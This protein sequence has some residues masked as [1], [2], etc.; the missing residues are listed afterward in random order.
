[1]LSKLLDTQEQ[2][3]T[4]LLSLLE[5]ENQSL[6]QDDMSQLQAVTKQKHELL[7]AIQQTDQTLAQHA[8]QL[9]TDSDLAKRV[10]VL[11]SLLSECQQH[12]EVNGALVNESQENV[13]QLRRVVDQLRFEGTSTYDKDG[14]KHSSQ[15]SGRGFKA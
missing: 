13:E 8:E 1:M 6:V 4:L 2:Q 12:N 15:R 5:K 14:K 11:Q 3:L 10:E 7:D 9:K